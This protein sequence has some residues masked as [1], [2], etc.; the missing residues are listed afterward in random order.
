MVEGRFSRDQEGAWVRRVIALTDHTSLQMRDAYPQIQRHIALMRG[1]RVRWG[2]VPA[3]FCTYGRHLP[4][5]D[6]VRRL[7]VRV[8]VVVGFPDGQLPM[9][10]YL[11]E[12]QWSVRWRV[13]EI[14]VVPWWG[15]WWSGHTTQVLQELRWLVAQ[16]PSAVWKVIL[17]VNLWSSPAELY[18]ACLEILHEVDVAFLKTSTGRYG[19]PTVDRV[20]PVLEAIR[21]YWR[22]TGKR[23]GVKISGGIRTL[24][25]A[26]RWLDL[27]QEVLG[28]EWLT[29]EYVRLGASRLLF[30]LDSH[31]G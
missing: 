23:V 9:S 6:G 16:A 10:A 27:V 4:Y 1:L 22:A 13:H 28:E 5:L 30:S 3:A 12:V 17:E 29:P 11:A 18:F 24:A 21:A 20:R 26:R 25:D 14:D 31:A 15:A 2:V 8:A 19:A 7:G